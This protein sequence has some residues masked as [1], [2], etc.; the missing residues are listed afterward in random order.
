MARR[1]TVVGPYTDVPFGAIIREAWEAS[2]MTQLEFARR[3]GVQQP[4]IPE[5]FASASITEALLDRCV[6]ALGHVLEV[7]IN[8]EGRR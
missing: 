6:E 7:R 1:K 5:I 8:R 4:R 2:G 3:L